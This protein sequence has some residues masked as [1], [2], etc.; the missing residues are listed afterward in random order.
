MMRAGKLLLGALVGALLGFYLTV[1]IFV[2]KARVGLYVYS[3]E[4]I[5]A[6]RWEMLPTAAGL[7]VGALLGGKDP[8]R[9]GMVVGWAMVGALVAIP[10]GWFGGP[11]FWPGRSAPWAGAALAAAMGLL[12][13]GALGAARRAFPE[14][15]LP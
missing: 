2:A 7:V 12:C 6:F 10:V 1:A 11:G 14:E 8:R 4:D 15:E 5:T 13:G 3:L 9:L